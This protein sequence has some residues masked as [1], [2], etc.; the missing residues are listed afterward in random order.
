MQEGAVHTSSDG[1]IRSANLACQQMFGYRENELTG[2]HVSTLDAASL[3]LGTDPIVTAMVQQQTVWSVPTIGIRKSG[4][5]F[6]MNLT[7]VCLG[8]SN[9]D[10]KDIGFM[11]YFQDNAP[12]GTSIKEDST[13]FLQA[14]A[15]VKA[16]RQI[17][18]LLSHEFRT[19]LTAILGFAN[20]LQ[21]DSRFDDETVHKYLKHIVESA[22]RLSQT[23]ESVIEYARLDTENLIPENS[24]IFLTEQLETLATRYADYLDRKDVMF[25]VHISERVPA[26]IET[27]R[28]KLVRILCILLDNALK[29]TEEGEITF[30]TDYDVENNQ[31]IF[32]VSDTGTGITESD[33]PN[34]FRPFWQAEEPLS[35][36][37]PGLGM[38]LAIADRLADTLGGELTA[39]PLE[40]G[41]EFTLSLPLMS[42]EQ[43]PV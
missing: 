24:R 31:L 15:A 29:F 21:E 13:M 37:Y 35:R 7:V 23:T 42:T 2:I 14:R 41:S 25:N 32:R 43:E 33:V 26:M 6:P 30:S 11:V 19:P 17:V 18:S 36:S 38:G 28:G 4:T 5:N 10:E 34:M 12:P 40:T 22:E 20:L 27:D 3:P 1:V 16:K 9:G 39:V 8:S